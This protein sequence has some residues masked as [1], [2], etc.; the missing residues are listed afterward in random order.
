[1]SVD[2]RW[3]VHCG[4]RYCLQ[5]AVATALKISSQRFLEL[6]W[7]LKIDQQE[8]KIFI[9]S[10]VWEIPR[11]FFHFVCFVL[12]VKTN[13]PLIVLFFH[14]FSFSRDFFF[15]PIV[16]YFLHVMDFKK[17]LL[18]STARSSKAAERKKNFSS[19]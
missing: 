14:R 17:N 4:A 11:K 7:L 16:A 3:K 13:Q 10:S 19:F 6:L 1:M 15:A 18:G 2:S 12:L 5:I 8:W 9:L